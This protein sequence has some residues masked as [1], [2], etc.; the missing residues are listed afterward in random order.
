MDAAGVSR[1]A[2]DA[3]DLAEALWAVTRPGP[4]RQAQVQRGREMFR[5]EPAGLVLSAAGSDLQLVTVPSRHRAVSLVSR[6]AAAVVALSALGWAG[7]TTGVA[8]ATEAGAGVAH[9]EHNSL[10]VAYVGVRLNGAELSDPA[11]VGALRAMN[12]T[13][14]VDDSTAKANVTALRT[15]AA[16]GINVEN[17]GVG[18]STG[19]LQHDH[20]AL[21]WT[22]ARRDARAG[23][24]LELLINR[25]VKETVPGRRLT[26]WDLLQCRDAHTSLVVPDHTI[27]VS[28]AG[29]SGPLR[30][31]GH[32]I[33]LI[34]G[35]G[36]TPPALVAFLAE[37][38]AGLQVA[39]LSASPL[40]TL[41]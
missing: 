36:A 13:A 25:P 29:S 37:L 32:D 20:D 6:A 19:A 15:L 34:N 5:A 27:T 10:A 24:Q 2:L 30:L 35:L 21:P 23:T 40:A 3:P 11:V 31:S 26:A 12:L 39:H 4:A 7:L 18:E 17:G 41:A 38:E 28:G 33:Y 22:R 8:M 9:P 16:D 1:L 14:V